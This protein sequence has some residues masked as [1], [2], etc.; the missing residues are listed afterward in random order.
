MQ[1]KAYKLIVP[2]RSLNNSRHN[3]PP[4]NTHIH[5]NIRTICAC[6]H[7][8]THTH[9]HIHTHTHLHTLFRAC[10]HTH[11]PHTHTH[12]L[13]HTR[14]HTHTHTRTRTHTHTHTTDSIMQYMSKSVNH[15]KNLIVVKS[16]PT[17]PRV[18][19]SGTPYRYIG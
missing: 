5:T 16:V 2:V 4:S 7:A 9:T 1:N 14:T 13:T 17:R 8:R 10:A 18:A 15:S 11:T 19:D 12:T 6:L 3:L